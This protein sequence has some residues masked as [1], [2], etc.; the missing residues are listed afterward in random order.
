M[1]IPKNQ[2]IENQY[3]SGGEY[4]NT[5]NNLIYSGYYCIVSGRYFIGKT[6]DLY[7]IELKP[8]NIQEVDKLN[9]INNLP[10]NLPNS[11]SQ[12][13]VSSVMDTQVN[14]ISVSKNSEKGNFRYFSKQTNI[15]PIIIK[16]VSQSTFNNI[17]TNPLYQ[18]LAINSNAIFDNSA[19]LNEA[20]KTFVGLKDF[21]S[22]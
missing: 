20:D 11:L 15:F 18:T 8:L 5:S 1:K 3:T 21:L 4:V 10:N 2:L 12:K 7:A 19:V 22:S 14:V 16:E 13:I 17:K 9:I 6:F